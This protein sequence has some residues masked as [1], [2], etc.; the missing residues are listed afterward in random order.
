MYSRTTSLAF[1]CLDCGASLETWKGIDGWSTDDLRRGTEN[2]LLAPSY[3]DRLWTLLESQ[4]NFGEFLGQRMRGWL[5]P[6]VTG[7]YTFWISADDQGE[8]WLSTDDNPENVFLAC[9]VPAATP[10]REWK[11][12]YH[13]QS[14]PINLVAGEAYYFEVRVLIH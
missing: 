1:S 5:K 2:F 4:S 7:N 9:K 12:F 8:L 13:Q 3:T 6:P 14:S 11:W 10:S